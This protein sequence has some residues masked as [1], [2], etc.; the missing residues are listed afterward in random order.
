MIK[1]IASVSTLNLFITE[2]EFTS[3]IDVIDRFEK[4]TYGEEHCTNQE[5]LL[6][7]VCKILFT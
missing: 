7:Y 1:I 3:Q 4:N 2:T 5:T 6:S